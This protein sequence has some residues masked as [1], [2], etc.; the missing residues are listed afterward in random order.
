MSKHSNDSR[1]LIYMVLPVLVAAFGL[2]FSLSVALVAQPGTTRVAVLVPPGFVAPWIAINRSG[3]PVVRVLLGGLLVVVDGS[4]APAALSILRFAPIV[5]L[6]AAKVPGCT[7]P[8]ANT[9]RAA[10]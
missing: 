10:L 6:D 4:K 1:K 7:D 3:L 8:V 2:F 9:E 5:L